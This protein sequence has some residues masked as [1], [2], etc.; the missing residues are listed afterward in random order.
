MTQLFANLGELALLVVAIWLARDAVKDARASLD[1]SERAVKLAGE[2]LTWA[3][4]HAVENERLKV[5]LAE[6][7]RLWRNLLAKNQRKR[8]KEI[9]ATPINITRDHAAPTTG[10]T[11][12]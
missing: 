7:K 2:A 8:Y 12:P 10:D 9:D 1:T 3:I 6:T 4:G 11:R 5:E